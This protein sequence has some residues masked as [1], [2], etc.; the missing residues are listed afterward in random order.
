MDAS[1]ARRPRGISRGAKIVLALAGAGALNRKTTGVRA[2]NRI[3]AGVNRFKAGASNIWAGVAAIPSKLNQ[4]RRNAVVNELTNAFLSMDGRI[5][6]I[7]GRL[8]T[9]NRPNKSC[10]Y[11][12]QRQRTSLQKEKNAII[13]AI[14][15]NTAALVNPNAKKSLE[16]FGRMSGTR[17][18]FT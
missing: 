4:A 13:R 5:H 12:C 9:L 11:V 10:G 8:K 16:V 3:G 14:K 15:R 2:V 6:Y 7:N 1:R 17:I 18:P